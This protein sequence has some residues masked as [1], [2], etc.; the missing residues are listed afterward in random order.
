MKVTAVFVVACCFTIGIYSWL[1][2]TDLNLS[3]VFHAGCLLYILN[4]KHGITSATPV[5]I[6]E[7]LKS[8]IKLV[9]RSSSTGVNFKVIYAIKCTNY[10]TTIFNHWNRKYPRAVTHGTG[11]SAGERGA[12]SRSCSCVGLFLFSSPFCRHIATK[13]VISCKS[14]DRRSTYKEPHCSPTLW[15][16]EKCAADA[17]S[18]RCLAV[19]MTRT[20]HCSWR[21][22]RLP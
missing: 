22:D 15:P 8:G 9:S 21:S 4:A 3:S 2:H 11:T 10:T 16:T 18:D 1:V 6:G 12:G 17:T 14:Y 20:N 5:S 7:L 13:R 19:H